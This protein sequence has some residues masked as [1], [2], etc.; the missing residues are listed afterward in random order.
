MSVKALS[1]AD[2]L[3]TFIDDYSRKTWIY[4]LKTEDEVF[5]RFKEFKALVE[6]L[7]W[8]KI[9]VLCS[10]NGGDYVDK[11]FTDY[12]AKED[13]RIEWTTPY[14]PEQNGVVERKNRTIVEA[15]RSMLYD[16]DM[17]KFL[18]VKACNTTVYV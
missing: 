7:T 16:Q 6:N 14:N 12:C 10:D 13:I 17:P 11:E 1:S 9:Q 2:Y 3:L 15:A 4:F 8:K 5:Y 18:W